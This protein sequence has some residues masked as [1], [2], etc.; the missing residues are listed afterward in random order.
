MR[1]SGFIFQ[2]CNGRE[3][4]ENDLLFPCTRFMV[5]DEKYNKLFRNASKEVLELKFR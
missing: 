5:L 2:K 3:L 4:Q 1:K